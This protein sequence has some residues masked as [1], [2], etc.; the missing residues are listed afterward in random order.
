MNNFFSQFVLGG[1]GR[2][3][4]LWANFPGMKFYGA[5]SS[6]YKCVTYLGYFEVCWRTLPSSAIFCLDTGSTHD[7]YIWHRSNLRKDMIANREEGYLIADATYPLES[8]L[9]THFANPRGDDQKAFNR[10][11]KTLRSR[12]ETAIGRWKGRFR[13]LDRSGGFLQYDP[14]KAC[15]I[16]AATAVLFNFLVHFLCTQFSDYVLEH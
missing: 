14:P 12:V 8:V 5:S 9:L 7:A 15:R 2:I 6:P 4:S 11:F 13:C 10:A 3:L 16:I 1:A